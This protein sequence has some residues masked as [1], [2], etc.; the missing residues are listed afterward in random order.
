MTMMELS[1]VLFYCEETLKQYKQLALLRFCYR[2]S[3]YAS[4]V[5]AIETLSVRLSVRHTRVLGDKTKQCTADIVIPH[6]AVTD[7]TMEPTVAA[8]ET[9]PG[10]SIDSMTFDP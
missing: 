1:I 8:Y 6:D 4:A 5:L 2:D 3:S 7:T 10:L 9:D